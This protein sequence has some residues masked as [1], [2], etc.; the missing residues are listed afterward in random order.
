MFGTPHKSLTLISI[1]IAWSLNSTISYWQ[2]DM[3]MLRSRVIVRIGRVV[4]N[5]LLTLSCGGM[6]SWPYTLIGLYAENG[7]C[8]TKIVPNTI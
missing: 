5:S 1:S 8:D 3:N 4:V 6:G 7:L 2:V